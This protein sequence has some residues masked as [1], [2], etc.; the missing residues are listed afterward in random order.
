M[1]S[2]WINKTKN[3]KCILYFSGWAMDENAISHLEF[4]DFDVCMFN[5][6]QALTAIDTKEFKQYAEIYVIAWSMGVWV[7]AKSLTNTKLKICKAIAINGTLNP[8]DAQNGIP[9]DIFEAT[10]KGWDEKNRMR[11]NM[12]VL[13]GLAQYKTHNNKI[14]KQSLSTQLKE[15]KYL[16]QEVI[17][18]E[19]Q[20]FQYE[21]ALIGTNDHIFPTSNQLNHWTG[22]TRIIEKDLPHFPF[23][24]FENWKQIIEL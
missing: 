2:N 7:G 21:S 9:P 8:I 3:S 17:N 23:L 14:G 19:A 13:G 18:S 20:T 11:F 16:Q 15:L 6:Y 24:T 1:Q 22:K 12:R 5:N 4:E 10:I